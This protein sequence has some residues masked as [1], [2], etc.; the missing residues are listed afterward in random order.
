MEISF[1]DCILAEV[2]KKAHMKSNDEYSILF[3]D[4]IK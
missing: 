2:S 3:L 4:S 1:S